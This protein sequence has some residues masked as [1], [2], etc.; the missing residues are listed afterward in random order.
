MNKIII[1][2]G[3]VTFILKIRYY[4]YIIIFNKNEKELENHWSNFGEINLNIG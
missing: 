1:I 2:Y 4:S 3:K